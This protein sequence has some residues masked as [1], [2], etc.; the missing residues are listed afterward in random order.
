MLTGRKL[1]L[2]DDSITIQKVIDLT[3]TDEGMKVTTVGTGDLVIE[4]LEADAPDI[5]LADVFMPGLTG[6]EVCERIKRDERFGHIPVMLLVGAFEP[7]NE[8]EARRVGADGFLTKPFQS[9]RGLVN[10]VGSLL[11]NRTSEDE[12]AE[13]QPRLGERAPR[14]SENMSVEEIEEPRLADTFTSLLNSTGEVTSTARLITPD[15][16]PSVKELF[17]DEA[18]DDQMIEAT[19]AKKFGSASGSRATTPLVAAA[20]AMGG[21]PTNLSRE[22]EDLQNLNPLEPRLFASESDDRSVQPAYATR[23]ASA[24]SA[25]DALLDLG[26]NEPPPLAVEADDFILD[27]ADETPA[28]QPPPTAT[29]SRATTAAAYGED[30]LTFAASAS[31]IASP[32]ATTEGPTGAT[33]ES[34]HTSPA[35]EA[36]RDAVQ[37]ATQDAMAQQVDLDQLPPEVIDRIARRAVEHLSEKVIREIAWEVVPQLAELLIK[38]RLEEERSKSQ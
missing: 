30:P 14:V 18:M 33:A 9:I 36:T 20:E 28:P 1:L 23:M 16:E 2:A 31:T 13:D 26:D 27:L 5:V 22:G 32:A 21:Q 6:Y 10:K 24:A 19:P 34:D 38:R 29:S 8:A 15:S 12:T 7:F 17:A 37:N 11:T 4:R 35:R 25:D 3:F